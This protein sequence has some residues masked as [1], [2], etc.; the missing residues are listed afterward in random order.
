VY[1]HPGLESAEAVL[2][3]QHA[4]YVNECESSVR[5]LS[6]THRAQVDALQ[7][8]LAR[9]NATVAALNSAMQQSA[10]GCR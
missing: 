7:L 10:E 3:Q 4:A 8:Q 2:R 1:T 5:E 9:T 6:S